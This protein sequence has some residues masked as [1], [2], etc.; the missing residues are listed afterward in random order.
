MLFSKEVLELDNI[1]FLILQKAYKIASKL[2]NA[3]FATTIDT[4]YYSKY[5]QEE[6]RIILHKSSKDRTISKEY[7]IIT[8]LNC[9]VKVAKKII[10]TRIIYLAK[11]SLYNKDIL[12]YKQIRG[13]KRTNN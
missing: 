13:K 12:N 5:W 7:R 2:F 4:R 8:P 10:V 11:N 1:T 3:I 9:F 6:I